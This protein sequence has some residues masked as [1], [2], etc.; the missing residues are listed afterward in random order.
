MNDDG[1]YEL[2]ALDD[3]DTLLF[4][5]DSGSGTVFG[6][7]SSG[8]VIKYTEDADAT[9]ESKKMGSGKG[10]ASAVAAHIIG[11][12]DALV[13]GVSNTGDVSDSV[14]CLVPPPPK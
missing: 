2:V 10:Q 8:D 3:C 1:F 7:F 14:F 12:G 13:F 4:V 11:N 5:V 6:P 9:P